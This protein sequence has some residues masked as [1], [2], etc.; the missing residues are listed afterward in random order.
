MCQRLKSFPGVNA[1]SGLPD[2]GAARPMRGQLHSP[3]T[4]PSQ[5]VRRQHRRS[6]GGLAIELDGEMHA[7]QRE[8]Y[9]MPRCSRPLLAQAAPP[10]R[11]RKAEDSSR[12]GDDPRRAKHRR[13]KP[14]RRDT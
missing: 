6:G 5:P 3:M 14:L 9:Q 4:P 2:A 12:F 8:R 7:S 11:Q 1:G 13:H 10:E